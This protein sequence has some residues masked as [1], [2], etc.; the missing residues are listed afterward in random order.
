M[1][2]L[3]C[4]LSALVL[5]CTYLTCLGWHT[6]LSKIRYRPAMLSQLQGIPLHRCTLTR[7][8]P[9]DIYSCF[10]SIINRDVTNVLKGTTPHSLIHIPVSRSP[11]RGIAKAKG[12]YF[13]F[14][15]LTHLPNFHPQVLHQ[16]PLS[17][18]HGGL[19]L[20]PTPCPE[21]G[22]SKRVNLHKPVRW[23]LYLVLLMDIFK[24]ISKMGLLSICFMRLLSCGLI[25]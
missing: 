13:F 8:L 9:G 2:V 11:V 18:H 3:S 17:A 25:A 22:I 12:W 4:I 7:P 1:S 20:F 23:K 15:F 16:F 24:N 6:K 19:C 21:K 5:F 10:F 14:F